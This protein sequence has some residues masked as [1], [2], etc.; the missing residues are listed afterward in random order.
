[1]KK[2]GYAILAFGVAFIVF[3]A[4]VPP[5]FGG[6]ILPSADPPTNEPPPSGAILDLNGLPIPGNGN[7]TTFQSYSV[8]FTAAFSSTAITFAFRDD[9]A[10]LIFQN[11]SV[12][13]LTTSSGNLLTNGDF[14]G[15][16]YTDNGNSLTPNGWT[17]ANVYGAFDGGVVQTYLGSPSWYDGAVQAYDAISQTIGTTV[18]DNYQ[19]SFYLAENNE[20]RD[21]VFSA[22]STN[23]DVTN[24]DGNGIDVLTY[25]QAVPEP[26]TMLLLGSGLIGLAG[27]WRK[28]FFKK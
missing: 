28:K 3:T 26:S 12:V 16:T 21:S 7:G 5:S 2:S 18:G 6:S 17:Y 1:M 9:P 27:L 10:F 8:T 20:G 11:A 22:L 24:A 23:G 14:S 4:M 15:G 19:I 25:A 13:D